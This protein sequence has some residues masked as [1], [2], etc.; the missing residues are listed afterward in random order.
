LGPQQPRRRRRDA[1]RLKSAV[2]SDRHRRSTGLN[3]TDRPDPT[4]PTPRARLSRCSSNKRAVKA[5]DQKKLLWRATVKKNA[6]AGVSG[7]KRKPLELGANING[8]SSA[9]RRRNAN[10]RTDRG[11]ASSWSDENSRIAMLSKPESRFLAARRPGDW[12]NLAACRTSPTASLRYEAACVCTRER[13]S[14]SVSPGRS[15]LPIERWR[16]FFFFFELYGQSGR[17]DSSGKGEEKR[18]V[19]GLDCS[20]PKHCDDPA[21]TSEIVGNSAEV[22]T[23]ADSLTGEARGV[24]RLAIREKPQ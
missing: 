15:E 10:R 18:R 6:E 23:R 21:Q 17:K 9:Q 7:Q 14:E 12:H 5:R 11:R 19:G 22:P 16:S 20:E 8:R 3:P 4:W 13:I 24:R 2:A 1:R